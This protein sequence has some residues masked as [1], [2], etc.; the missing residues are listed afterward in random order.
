M[1]TLSH[2]LSDKE[3]NLVTVS[4]LLTSCEFYTIAGSIIA[5]LDGSSYK[6]DKV[7]QLNQGRNG[8]NAIH[9]NGHFL[10]VGG[11]GSYETEKCE[12]KNNQMVCHSQ[13]PRLSYNALTPELMTVFDDYCD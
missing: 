9:L 5:R 4:N 2:F 3:S 13:S 11:Y 7:G 1:P 8:H 10:V 12:Y 6:W